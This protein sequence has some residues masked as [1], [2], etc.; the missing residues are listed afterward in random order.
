MQIDLSILDN[1]YVA[2]FLA[3]FVALY[4]IALSRV[5]LPDF[6]R[7]LFNNN[8]FRVLFLSLLMI[9][10]FDRS[11]HVAVIVALLFVLTMQYID[12]KETE[13]TFAYVGNVMNR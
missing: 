4:G 3:L 8:I 1:D 11:P 7:N 5:K 9:H 6:I 13:E 12:D 10:N 2:T